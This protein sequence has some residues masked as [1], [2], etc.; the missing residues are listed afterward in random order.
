MHKSTVLYFLGLFLKIFSAII[1]LPLIVGSIYGESFVTL[2]SYIYTSFIAIVLGFLFTHYGIKK[3]PTLVETSLIA[4]FSWIFAVLLGAIPFIQILKMPYIDAFFE[5]MSGFTTGG[6]TLIPTLE[7]VPVS[8]LFLRSF[9]QWVGGLGI[10]TLFTMFIF[11]G[12]GIANQIFNAEA[13]KTKNTRTQPNFLKSTISL[14]KIYLIIT[15]LLASSLV[16]LKLSIFDAI[17]HSFT[18]IST[19]GFSNYDNGI[20]HFN[21][22]FIEAVILI[23]MFI[24]GINFILL[25]DAFKG[26][27]MRL[28]KDF[29]AR[30]YFYIFLI[31]SAIMT[32]DFTLHGQTLSES[33]H[34]GLFNSAA[35]ISTT[36]ITN[37]DISFFPQI[38]MLL[39]IV[40]LF[41]GGS[42]GST[43]GGIKMLRFGTL[44]K[45]IK[46]EIKSMD[47]PTRAIDSII[48]NKKIVDDKNIIKIGTIIVLWI[49]TIFLGSAI[50]IIY[51]D[52]SLFTAITNMVSVVSTTGLLFISSESVILLPTAVKITY[53]IGML[54]GRLEMIPLLALFKLRLL[55]RK[56]G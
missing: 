26:N 13:H 28:L 41:I 11:G 42:V 45:L 9:M 53:M 7:G 36:G 47:S 24:G 40:L 37:T 6:I 15:V 52:M 51:T 44:L 5:A 12:G 43:S 2:E 56:T 39:I 20:L 10:L 32:L 14:W 38:S 1:I 8:I 4:I 48:I 27:L 25:F 33:L 19:G 3:Q 49:V 21:N 30:I 55:S 17:T 23:F 29:E 54:A 46:R 18:T 22:L 16:I 50:T 35:I 34:L 31:A